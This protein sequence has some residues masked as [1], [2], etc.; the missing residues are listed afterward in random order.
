[1]MVDIACLYTSWE[2]PSRR[3]RTQKLSNQLTTPC[4]FTPLTRKMVSGVLDLRTEFRKVS[5]RFCFF[6]ADITSG[7]PY[8]SIEGPS[9]P[10]TSRTLGPAIVGQQG[11]ARIRP[12]SGGR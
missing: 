8:V 9:P 6:S 3:N 10:H 5:W 11:L 1:M 2:C 4:S 7:P 12:Q